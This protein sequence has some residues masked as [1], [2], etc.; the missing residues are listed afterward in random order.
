[1]KKK[2]PILQEFEEG[3]LCFKPTYKFDRFSDTYDTRYVHTLHFINTINIRYFQS[4]K[5][6][7]VLDLNF[8]KVCHVFLE[9]IHGHSF[10]TQT[11]EDMVWLYVRFDKKY[12]CLLHGLISA[13]TTITQN[14]SLSSPNPCKTLHSSH[15]VFNLCIISSQ[16]ALV[17]ISVMSI[18][19]YC[20]DWCFALHFTFMHLADAFIQ[21]NLY[22]IQ[23][24]HFYCL[25]VCSLGIEPTTFA[26]LMQCSTTEPQEHWDFFCVP[27]AFGFED[28][29]VVVCLLW[30]WDGHVG[31][32]KNG[33]VFPIKHKWLN[34]GDLPHHRVFVW[35]FSTV[36]FLI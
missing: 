21:I 9:E 6:E 18:Q 30:R 19:M 32:C 27:A 11:T 12:L 31:C 36:F 28:M 23:D 1:M 15:P 34:T 24:I 14:S 10:S 5:V 8:L 25:Y 22:P 26:L 29:Y 2:E 35:V 4:M 20:R 7:T 33:I 17:R 13:L 16:D 3:Q